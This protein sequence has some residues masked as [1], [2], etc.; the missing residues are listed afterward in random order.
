MCVSTMRSMRLSNFR[1]VEVRPSVSHTN[2]PVLLQCWTRLHS[3]WQ[4]QLCTVLNQ[5]ALLLP[6]GIDLRRQGTFFSAAAVGRTQ[7]QR[8]QS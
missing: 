3:L 4:L 8:L 5:G 6:A 7:N 1:S 2:F